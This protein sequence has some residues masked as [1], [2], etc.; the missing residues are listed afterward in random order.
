MKGKIPTVKIGRGVP[1]KKEWG[2]E[3]YNLI[4]QK[5]SMCPDVP[6]IFASPG[7]ST[8]PSTEKPYPHVCLMPRERTRLAVF[9]LVLPERPLGEA[10]PG[11]ILGPITHAK[12]HLHLH[13]HTLADI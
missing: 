10:P 8:G 13:T 9:M 3:F 7:A 2:W 4:N 1:K 11:C 5:G 6:L 12:L